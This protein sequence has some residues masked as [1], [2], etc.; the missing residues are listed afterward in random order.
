MTK[1]QPTNEDRRS[2]SQGERNT[3]ILKKESCIR[4]IIKFTL[5]FEKEEVRVRRGYKVS[6]TM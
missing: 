4:Y 6:K 1:P 3:I 2:Q 5:Y